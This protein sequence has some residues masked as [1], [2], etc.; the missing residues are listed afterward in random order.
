MRE[1]DSELDE[2][3]SDPQDLEVVH[4][5][6]SARPAAPPLDPHFRSYLR[7]KL[8]AE[9]RRTLPARPRRPWFGIAPMPAMAAVAATFI[10]VLGYEL[11]QRGQAPAA[12]APIR[13]TAQVD[14]TNAA[15]AEPIRLQF[16]GAVDRTAVE[17]SIVIQPATQY[18]TRWEGQTLV[19]IPLHQLAASTTY[20]VALLPAPASTPHP[21]ATA[22]PAPTPAPT[23]VVV[24][25]VTAPAPPPPVTPP[26]FASANITFIGDSR[27]ADAGTFGVATWT[28]DGQI[29]ATR[30]A[31]NGRP[32]ARPSASSTPSGTP[33]A[34]APAAAPVT[35]KAMD[36]WLMSPSGKFVRPLA[37]DV[38]YPAAAPQDGTVAFWHPA[39]DRYALMETTTGDLAGQA[40]QLAIVTGPP[41]A[42]P[43]WL[44][45]DRI[46][47]VDAGQLHVVDLLGN[48]VPLAAPIPVSGAAAPSLDGHRL[49]VQT[50][51]GAA[52]YDLT[53]GRST[54]LPEGATAFSWS[55]KGDLAFAVQN[56]TGS[57]LFVLGAT[58]LKPHAV[59]S[60]AAGELWSNFNWS[61]DA[62]SLLFT[63]RSGSPASGTSSVALLVDAAGSTPR[64]FGG[65]PYETLQWSPD[66]R[67]VLLTRR[68]ETGQAALWVATLKV[69]TLSDVERAQQEALAVVKTFMDARLANDSA[70]AS[71]QLSAAGTAAYQQAGLA[72][73]SPGSPRFE[74][75]YPVTVQLIDKD[76]FLI[77]VRIVQARDKVETG[78]YEEHLTVARHDQTFLIDGVQ[79]SAPVSLSAGGPAVVSVEVR[80]E[81]AGQRILVH[82]DSDLAVDTVNQTAIVI[83]DGNDVPQHVLDLSYD[84]QTHLVTLRT[85]LAPGSYKL[86]VTTSLQDVNGKSLAQDYSAPLVITG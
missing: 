74:R 49:A 60:S 76:S 38:L 3:F 47:Y 53:S 2:L 33:A 54:A 15:P 28:G 48:P 57:A 50:P 29:M 58:E 1:R 83:R 18:T 4:L 85:K 68:D 72:L 67:L 35:G 27:L 36:L 11:Y 63:S 12:P 79:P 23:P 6:R 22:A 5:L 19:V 84:Q 25:F 44:G 73:L 51:A 32:S 78:F 39:G 69:G 70:T 20:T 34:T 43:V 64:P 62:V 59:A 82:F 65:R 9:A 81:G 71:Q 24:R 41:S 80:Q 56:P 16:S 7:G 13:V 75:W 86:V 46:A 55:P 61:P 66:G 77:G 37:T 26:A 17:E 30:P 31:L 40:N 14:R 8:I 10:L 45:A 42:P 21:S 52:V